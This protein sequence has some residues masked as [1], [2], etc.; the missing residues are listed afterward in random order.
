MFDAS[1]L[2][3]FFAVAIFAWLCCDVELLDRGHI[4]DV[5]AL[6]WVALALHCNLG[7]GY[8]NPQGRPTPVAGVVL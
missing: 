6:R 8:L 4:R 5:F 2:S 3:A 1:L 7:T